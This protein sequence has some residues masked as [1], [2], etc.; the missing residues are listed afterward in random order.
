[1]VSKLWAVVPWGTKQTPRAPGIFQTL[2]GKIESF[3][4]GPPHVDD[5]LRSFVVSVLDGVMFFVE[6]SHC[7]KMKS[8]EKKQGGGCI[9]LQGLL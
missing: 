8:R 1:M 3:T 5:W 4:S 6:G 9:R 2:V 7:N